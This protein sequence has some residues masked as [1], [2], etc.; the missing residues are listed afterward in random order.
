M[1]WLRVALVGL[2]VAIVLGSIPQAQAAD[3]GST[4]HI[5]GEGEGDP[6]GAFQVLRLHPIPTSMNFGDAVRGV[7]SG[8]SWLVGV[9]QKTFFS[10]DA[11]NHW[12]QLDPLTLF[13]TAAGGLCCQQAFAYD[14][15]RD[16]FI[17]L[18][19]Y[20]PDAQRGLV[21]IA[22]TNSAGLAEQ[23]WEW[24]DVPAAQ[25]FTWV[26]PQL[27][28]SANQIWL[29]MERQAIGGAID[30]IW[31]SQIQ[32]D[33]LEDDLPFIRSYSSSTER[34]WHLVRGAK[35]MMYFATHIN[36]T[37][38]R[39]YAWD[40][41]QPIPSSSD[42]NVAEWTAGARICPT[43]DQRNWCSDDD[44][45]IRAGWV[46]KGTVGFMWNAVSSNTITF[47][48]IDAVR[49]YERDL[50]LL[51]FSLARPF[52]FNAQNGFSLPS[53]AVNGRDDVAVSFYHSS[54]KQYPT[55]SSS[56]FDD[57]TAPPPGWAYYNV[58]G[59]STTPSQQHWVGQLD[60]QVFSPTNLG[61]SVTGARLNGCDEARC[62]QPF[63][64]IFSRERDRPAIERW[65]SP[66][67][68]ELFTPFVQMN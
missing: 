4:E 28:L 27:E 52:I 15:G 57:F 38:L 13:P 35:D 8:D 2:L 40:E 46:A 22:Y 51:P 67:R 59:S 5:F 53:V 62:L 47:P 44:G 34:A 48:Y 31:V 3:Q 25:G 65:L 9:G 32:T 16:L 56:I 58:Q 64:A 54:T 12:Q 1:V 29:A 45:R 36:Q 66:V 30:S 26:E 19:Q 60:T 21:R 14:Y 42:L 37:S 43:P 61:W 10:L 49:M 18:L 50:S 17:W 23:A 11:G 6:A 7:A 33:T 55:L 20:A 39:V 68:Y 41:N 24:Y 63:I